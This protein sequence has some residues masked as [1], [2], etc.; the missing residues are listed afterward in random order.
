MLLT[1]DTLFRMLS[2]ATRLRA[3]MLL[4]DEAELCVCE[5]T[6]A[7]QVSQPKVSR[8]LAQLRETGL[9]RARREGQ[10]M[11]YR[12]DPDLPAWVHA[13][14]QHTRQGNAHQ[15]PFSRDCTRLSGMPDRPGAACCA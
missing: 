4:L 3:V 7:L 8:H 14:L 10:W 1:P 15:V 5:L 13:I 12:I 2:D 11:Y 9:L 6:H